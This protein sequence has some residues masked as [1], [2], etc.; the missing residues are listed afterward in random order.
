[1]GLFTEL[2]EIR[3]RAK[4]QTSVQ[5]GALPGA[6]HTDTVRALRRAGYDVGALTFE[7]GLGYRVVCAD[8]VGVT[9]AV[10]DAQRRGSRRLRRR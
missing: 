1:M 4:G 3:R 2:A 6:T 9:A 8:P 10:A 7:E 5:L